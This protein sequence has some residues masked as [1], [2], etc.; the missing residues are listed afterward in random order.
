[1]LLLVVTT[2]WLG[3]MVVFGYV[4]D[5]AW[6]L[7][8][9]FVVLGLLNLV[10]PLYLLAKGA[11]LQPGEHKKRHMRVSPESFIDQVKAELNGE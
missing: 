7:K 1:M 2:W 11:Y 5:T 10:G 3:Y 9:L 6:Y 4:I 8:A